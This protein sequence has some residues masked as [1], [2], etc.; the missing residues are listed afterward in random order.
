MIIRPEIEK[1]LHRVMTSDSPTREIRCN[2]ASK[3][4][5]AQNCER[6][7]V[8]FLKCSEYSSFVSQTT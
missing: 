7:N 8:F 2:Y 5:K 4:E 6:C 3:C 1:R